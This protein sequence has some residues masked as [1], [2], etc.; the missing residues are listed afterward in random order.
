MS[1]GS[2]TA[3]ARPSDFA[4][5]VEGQREKIV[6]T[7][8][9][10]F[11][12]EAD[13][14]MRSIILAYN[15]DP[16]L[17]SCTTASIMLAAYRAC[18]L[19]LRVN[20]NSGHAYLIPYGKEVQLQIGYLGMI[21]L[22]YRTGKY[23]NIEARTVGK[24]DE[25]ICEWTPELQFRHKPADDQDP[26]QA[27]RVYAMAWMKGEDKPIIQVMSRKEVEQVR[28]ASRAGNSGPWTQY[29]G[30][31]AKK[32]VIKRLLKT[33]PKSDELERAMEIDNSDY[34]GVQ[35][36]APR[37]RGVAG[38]VQSIQ[39]ASPGQAAVAQEIQIEP[40]PVPAEATNDPHGLLDDGDDV[41]EA[42]RE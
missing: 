18:E 4:K 28:Q 34:Y 3:L 24:D 1:A 5:T 7:L 41:W 39:Q 37:P 6:A 9:M 21:E 17:Q 35:E 29:W 16:K 26:N 13:R 12:R 25:W 10:T 8:P 23:R 30:E 2:S 19:G 42:G 32:T 11:Q 15:K 14:F 38:L 33:L 22:A 27:I 36:A 40:E 31:M 20:T